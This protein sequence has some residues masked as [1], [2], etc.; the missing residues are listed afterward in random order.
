VSG[1]AGRL[2]V[3]LYAREGCHLCEEAKAV[4]L[5]LIEREGA[6][7]R[8]VDIDDD[9]DLRAVY[10]ESVPVIFVGAEFF[11]RYRVDTQ[12]FAEALEAAGSKS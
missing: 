10:N 8:E 7:L 4:M 11:A 5:P 2:V 6:E 3:T 1:E 12:K 9:A